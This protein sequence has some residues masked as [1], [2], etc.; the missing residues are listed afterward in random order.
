LAGELGTDSIEPAEEAD[1]AL[2]SLAT[3]PPVPL[4]RTEREFELLLGEST[5]VGL[6]AAERASSSRT[7]VLLSINSWRKKDG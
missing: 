5:E 4:E 7:T 3:P 1:E 6:G 2:R